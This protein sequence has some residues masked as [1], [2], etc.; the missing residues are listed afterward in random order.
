MKTIF[1]IFGLLVVFVFLLSIE[2]GNKPLF[3]HIY[4]F[5]S[6]VTKSA[7][8]ATENALSKSFDST[9]AYTKKLFNNSV[10]KLKDSVKSQLSS[11]KKGAEPAERITKGEKQELDQLIKG[12]K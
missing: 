4:G 1:S 7:Q 8:N 2:V 10:P 6:P 5:I 3:S 11:Q 12:H 9:E